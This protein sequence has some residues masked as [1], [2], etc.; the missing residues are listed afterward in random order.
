MAKSSGGAGRTGRGG[1]SATTPAQSLQTRSADIR[2]Q[3]KTNDKRANVLRNELSRN[4]NLTNAQIISRRDKIN[5][6]LRENLS[7]IKED[8]DITKQ[9]RL[10]L[11]KPSSPFSRPS[12]F[13]R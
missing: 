10:A 12:G 1:G 13:R 9:M 4:S 5:G 3:I 6:L 11:P 8:T 7:L 2:S